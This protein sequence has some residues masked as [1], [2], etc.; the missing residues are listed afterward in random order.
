MVD[1]RLHRSGLLLQHITTTPLRCTKLQQHRYQT[2]CARSRKWNLDLAESD[3][4]HEQMSSMGKKGLLLVLAATQT[5]R[6]LF[7]PRR[8]ANHVA[9][10]DAIRTREDIEFGLPLFT[11]LWAH[12]SWYTLAGHLLHSI[13]IHFHVSMQMSVQWKQ[14]YHY[15][16]GH[17]I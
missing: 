4:G 2:Y 17:S 7:S 3:Q 1:H 5:H 6:R 16:A 11:L 10:V 13:A 14:N 15:L 8:L 12:L 9:S